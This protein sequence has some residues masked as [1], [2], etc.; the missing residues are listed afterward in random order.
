MPI[1]SLWHWFSKTHGINLKLLLQSGLWDGIYHANNDFHKQLFYWLWL[2]ILQDQL[3]KY[4]N[5]VL[6]G[7]ALF[8]DAG[9]S[10]IL[11]QTAMT[12]VEI[13][14]QAWMQAA[15]AHS[16]KSTQGDVCDL[17]TTAGLNYAKNGSNQP[18]SDRIKIAVEVHIKGH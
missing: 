13:A 1:E 9:S 6:M 2:Q 11:S 4:V 16:K 14:R 7:L 10:S 3:H 12:A 8:A 15:S 18:G 5:G 17:N